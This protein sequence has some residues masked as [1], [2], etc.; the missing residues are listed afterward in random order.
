MR[1]IR[2]VLAAGTL[3]W[4]SGCAGSGPGLEDA[5]PRSYG[6]VPV[7]FSG[8]SFCGSPLPHPSPEGFFPIV[9][10]LA[11][12]GGRVRVVSIPGGMAFGVWTDERR[13][14]AIRSLA[15]AGNRT[16]P[17]RIAIRLSRLGSQ[18]PL[19]ESGKTVR[20][21]RPFLAARWR[22]GTQTMAVYGYFVRTGKIL[23]PLFDFERRN[24]STVYCMSASPGSLFPDISFGTDRATFKA[25]TT[26]L[27]IRWTDRADDDNHHND[28]GF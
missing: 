13:L 21:R 10:K 27:T 1:S 18:S 6:S 15:K 3:L 12:S 2:K 23:T 26:T 20:T 11:G 8:V 16:R 17:V 4:L 5:A 19:I 14:R 25:G 9:R 24:R 28:G 7:Y 22:N